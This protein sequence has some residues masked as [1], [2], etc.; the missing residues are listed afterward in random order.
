MT[1]RQ[2]KKNKNLAGVQNFSDELTFSCDE[3]SFCHENRHSE[4]FSVSLPDLH[5]FFRINLNN[6][7]PFIEN[8]T[9]IRF[10][11]L[12]EDTLCLILFDHRH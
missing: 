7:G 6:G 12:T 11:I 3:I 10:L 9:F 1:V 4:G 5:L 8:S 2:K